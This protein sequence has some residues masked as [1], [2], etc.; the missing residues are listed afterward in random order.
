M[1]E[2]RSRKAALK[3]SNK[4]LEYSFEATKKL[5]LDPVTL[6]NPDYEL[7]FVVY[8]DWSKEGIGFYLV[9]LRPKVPVEQIQVTGRILSGEEVLEFLTFG[10]PTGAAAVEPEAAP[11]A[12]EA[13]PF[14]ASGCFASCKREPES[15]Y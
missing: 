6:M 14:R 4:K 12:L 15:A 7:P 9:Q 1:E 5:F 11:G 13:L 3:K 2:E 8:S 10:P